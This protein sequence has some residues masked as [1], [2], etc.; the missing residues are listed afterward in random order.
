MDKKLPTTVKKYLSKLGKHG[1]MAR[2]DKKLAS[3][4]ANLEKARAKRW[5]NA[6]NINSSNDSHVVDSLKESCE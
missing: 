3:A 2:T 1:G 6:K 4:N 5:P